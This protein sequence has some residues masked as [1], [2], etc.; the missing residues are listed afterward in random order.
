MTSETNNMHR[1]EAPGL[2]REVTANSSLGDETSTGSH[3][4]ATLV[5]TTTA[6]TKFNSKEN[7]SPTAPR[8]VHGNKDGCGAV[9]VLGS[10]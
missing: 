7:G 4:K 6:S 1:R 10:K 3:G 8:D 5:G 2:M 9:V